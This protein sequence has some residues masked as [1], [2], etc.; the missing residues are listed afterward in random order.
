MIT[1]EAVRVEKPSASIAKFIENGELM[2]KIDPNH[3]NLLKNLGIFFLLPGG[4]SLFTGK[5]YFKRIIE[6]AEEPTSFFIVPCI[7][8]VFGGIILI[9]T[10]TCS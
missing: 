10:H 1:H 4:V 7:Y 5:T 2:C 8:L 3:A 9:A 6:R